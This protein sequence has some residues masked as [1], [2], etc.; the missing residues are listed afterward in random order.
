MTDRDTIEKMVNE[1]LDGTDLRLKV[2]RYSLEEDLES[3]DVRV[4]CH[5]HDERTG[6]QQTIEGR[7]V[8]L[9]D[10]FFLGLVSRYSQSF[11][12]LK[13]IRFADFAIKANVDTGRHT[14]RSDMAATVT[15]RVA[16]SE[17]R[18]FAFEHSS[19]SITGSSAAAVV[20]AVE[21]FINGERAFV[22][23]YGALQHAREQNRPD[24]VAR[25]TQQMSTIVE[26]TSYSEVIDQIKKTTLKR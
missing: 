24:S 8:G 15:L 18:E 14:A 10:A 11:P 2:D 12:S 20:K 13:S 23:L 17:N 26:S 16:N 25:Y 5:V 4:Q 3:G 6:E 22:A 1:V 9:V 19:T 21:F 7:G